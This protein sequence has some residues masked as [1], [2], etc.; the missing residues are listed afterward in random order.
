MFYK[1]MNIY[2][3][4]FF[5]SILSHCWTIPEI[6]LLVHCIRLQWNESC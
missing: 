1:K 5:F 2:I 3:Y 4:I 6:A